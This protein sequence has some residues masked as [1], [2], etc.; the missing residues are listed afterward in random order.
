MGT[1]ASTKKTFLCLSLLGGA[2]LLGLL[3]KDYG[4]LQVAFTLGSCPDF[5]SYIV[6]SSLHCKLCRT[7]RLD[8][9]VGDCSCEFE[10]VDAA[11][12]EYFHPILV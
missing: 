9:L 11:T 10:T 2:L 3:P 8:G 7:Q 6:P 4:A 1:A 5:L 12:H